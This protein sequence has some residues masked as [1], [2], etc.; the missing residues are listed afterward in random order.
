[1]FSTV[2]GSY[3]ATWTFCPDTLCRQWMGQ[4]LN[5]CSQLSVQRGLKSWKLQRQR[6]STKKPP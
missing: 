1:M 5:R 3:R 2:R 4:L 6:L